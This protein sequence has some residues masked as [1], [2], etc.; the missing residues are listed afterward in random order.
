[1]KS[2]AQYLAVAVAALALA[3]CDVTPEK[4][5][6][7]K[8]SQNGGAKLRAAVRD[9]DLSA[10]LRKLAA[11]ALADLGH[12][13]PLSEDLAAVSPT[14]KQML[15][16]HLVDH[17]SGVMVG[18]SEQ[19]T[20][21]VQL[22]A[23]D[24][25]FSLRPQVDAAKRAALDRRLLAWIVADWSGRK[26]GLHSATKIVHAIGK[27]A[28]SQLVAH[29]AADLKAVLPLSKLIGELGGPAEREAAAAKLAVGADAQWKEIAK[30][31]ATAA[32]AQGE[33]QESLKTFAL[34]A[35][36]LASTRADAARQTLMRHAQ[37]GPTVA[38]DLALRALALT[39]SDAVIPAMAALASDVTQPGDL[40]ERAFEVMEK[41][42]G[43]A[44]LEALAKLFAA[45]D[46]KVR[47]RA[48]EA[49]LSCCKVKGLAK[50]LEALP[51]RY[52]YKPEDVKDLIE[53]DARDLGKEALP[54]LRSALNSRSLIAR[55]IAVRLVGALGDA[56][57]VARLE[58]L[59]VD[60]S[61]I[62]GWDVNLGAEVK[63]AIERIRQR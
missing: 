61:R 37:G 8:N 55:L 26:A 3:G 53:N 6:I 60:S 25:L 5:A 39:A 12:F 27:P 24:A 30:H 43:P 11:V 18:P 57:D 49:T 31:A 41:V 45:T 2:L 22:S 10:E 48:I 36:A 16:G 20:S 51:S 4:I 47:Y 13:D 40:R 33:L 23:K 34:F 56:T 42:S 58:P 7:W 29:V 38:R 46:D 28:A 35:E 15:V 63:R 62:P 14:D 52:T 32:G 50:L 21:R 17:F 44:T 1:M 54:T 59:A 9:A 19:A